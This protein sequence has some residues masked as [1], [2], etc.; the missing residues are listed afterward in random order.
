CQE[1]GQSFR[2]GSELAVHGQFNDGKKPHK[3]LEC[4]KSFS[5]ISK[6]IQHQK[7]HTGEQP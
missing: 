3:S 5:W 7:I 6:L 1:G 4:R 2:R